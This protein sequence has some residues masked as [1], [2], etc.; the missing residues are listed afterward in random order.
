MLSSTQSLM[1]SEWLRHPVMTL[2]CFP[3]P[4]TKS[5]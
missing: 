5:S 3:V 4:P 2:R 1:L